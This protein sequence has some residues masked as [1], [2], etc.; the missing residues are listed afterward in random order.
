[1]GSVLRK[2]TCEAVRTISSIEEVSS[3]VQSIKGP[4]VVLVDIDYTLTRPVPPSK[5]LL[6]ECV[7]RTFREGAWP[8]RATSS[9]DD[10][11]EIRREMLQTAIVTS[12]PT[13]LIEPD[14]PTVIAHLREH[15]PC[16][17]FTA[18]KPGPFGQKASLAEWR[19]QI[20]HEL[21]ISFS[22]SLAGQTHLPLR[23]GFIEAA[24]FH[25]GV[26][27]ASG[28]NKGY[29]KGNVLRALLE[30]HLLFEEGAPG[31]IVMVDDHAGNLSFL[32]QVTQELCVPFIGF[33]YEG[34]VSYRNANAETLMDVL[35]EYQPPSP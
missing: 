31:T 23:S 14:A 32:S 19:F 34:G 6:A 24:C 4:A 20:L 9:D 30:D 27:F 11:A 15:F 8:Y 16:Y 33:Q 5:E 25:G 10:K 3:I 18:M 12:C 1:M 28:E 17:G 29:G 7:A 26:I 35:S 22:P 2:E 13:S 21:G